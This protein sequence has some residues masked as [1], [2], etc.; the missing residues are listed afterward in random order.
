MRKDKFDMQKQQ[1]DFPYHYLPYEKDSNNIKIYRTLDWGFEYLWYMK[2]IVSKIVDNHPASL[3]DVGCG[4]GRLLQMLCGKVKQLEGIDLVKKAV[5]FAQTFNVH[6]KV[7]LG[8][9]YMLEDKFECVT[10]VEVLEHIPNKEI[11]RFVKGLERLLE[12]NGC[13]IISVPSINKP[14]SKKHYRH[15]SIES[16]NRQILRN[17]P[18]LKLVEYKYVVQHSRLYNLFLKITMNKFLFLRIE[19]LDILLWKYLNKIFENANKENGMHVIAVYKK[20][21]K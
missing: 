19:K 9:L 13:L 1:Y 16:L 14:K 5:G 4:D 8:D 11:S 12:D 3:C 7:H 18:S 17:C 20:V 6:A 10:A 15:Y 2:Y 21:T